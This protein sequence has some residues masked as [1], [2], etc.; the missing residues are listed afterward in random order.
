MELTFRE[1]ENQKL[2]P[3]PII[4]NVLGNR[5]DVRSVLVDPFVKPLLLLQPLLQE[6]VSVS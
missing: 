6:V 1:I 2:D 4:M 3:P 5:R